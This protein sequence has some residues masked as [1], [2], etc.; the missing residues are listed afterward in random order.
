M[1][2]VP[3]QPKG[4]VEE[5]PWRDGRTITFRARVPFKGRRPRVAFGTNHEGWNPERAA[6][7]LER[8]MGLVERGTWE[9]PK[10]AKPESLAVE[11]E[12]LRVTATRFYERRKKE[13]LEPKTEKDYEWRLSYILSYKPGGNPEVSTEQIDAVWFDEFRDWLVGLTSEKTGEALS[14][15]SV[16]MILAI[17]AAVLDDAVRYK[18]LPANP[19]R[20]PKQRLKEE[21]KRR[22]ILEPDMVLDLLEAAGEWE[23][24]LRKRGQRHQCF[25]RR[26]LLA[27][28]I[29]AGPR[30]S[31]ATELERS[32]LDIHGERARIDKS[33]TEAGER[34]IDLTAFLLGE[35]RPHLAAS[36]SLLGHAPCPSTPVFHSYNGGP[37]NDNNFRNRVLPEIV[38]RANKKRAKEG[39]LLIPTDLTPHAFRR[40]FARLCFMAGRELDYVM[41][42]IGHKDATLAVEIY[43]QMRKGRTRRSE[44][45]IAWELMRFNDEGETFGEFAVHEPLPVA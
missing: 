22:P 12:T 45:A 25:G 5:H 16:N 11:A 41:G 29:L 14:P 27:F 24:G 34:D 37:V 23:D 4:E 10:P 6:I 1:A 42:Q 8:I 43:A 20:G 35:L 2:P 33:K 9:P 36:P 7:E 13:G 3:R 44:R 31:E 17:L 19:A 15:R 38:K 28:L 30:I 39:K 40:T 26:A 32:N 21:R 18:L